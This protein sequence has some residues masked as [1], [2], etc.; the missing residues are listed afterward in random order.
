MAKFATL[1]LGNGSTAGKPVRSAL[2]ILAESFRV[3]IDESV[4]PN[5]PCVQFTTTDDGRGTG[6]Q[7]IPLARLQDFCDE[8]ERFAE[9][10]ALTAQAASGDAV[11]VMRDTM[12]LVEKEGGHGPNDTIY[13]AF[14]T[15][16]GQG[17]KPTRL[18]VNE[19]GSVAAF[20]RSR[21]ESSELIVKNALAAREK[22]AK[23]V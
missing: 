11:E 15:A 7:T 23:K 16:R 12:A 8:F 17:M 14:R 1:D 18:P 21:I 5:V 19:I 22:A 4:T 3:G 6:A 10:G 20:L 13:C 2:T 9:P